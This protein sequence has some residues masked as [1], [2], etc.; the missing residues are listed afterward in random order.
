MKINCEEATE[1]CTRA[2]YGRL[3]IVN[4]LKLNFHLFMCKICGT[5]SKQNKILTKCMAEH[6]KR[7]HNGNAKLS[8]EEKETMIEVIKNEL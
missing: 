7:A 4:Q 8:D 6:V 2:Q 5:F 3:P 1:L